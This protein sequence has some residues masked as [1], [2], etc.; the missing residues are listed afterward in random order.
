VAGGAT[1]AGTLAGL[2]DGN[3]HGEGVA[4]GYRRGGG[5]HRGG[6]APVRRWRRASAAT[7][8][9]EGWRTVASDE[10]DGAM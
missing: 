8:L 3:H 1:L 2:H 10:G 9:S 6:A 5:A 4:L 7:F